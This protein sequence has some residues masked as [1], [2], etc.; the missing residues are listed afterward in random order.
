MKSVLS[1]VFACSALM[2]ASVAANATVDPSTPMYVI[3]HADLSLLALVAVA[4]DDQADSSE[5]ETMLA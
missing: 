2:L 3:V 1:K 5:A 4:D